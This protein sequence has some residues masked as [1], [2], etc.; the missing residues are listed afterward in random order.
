M[1]TFR[2][3]AYQ[4]ANWDWRTFDLDRDTALADK[5]AGFINALDPNL[6]KF[7]DRGGKLVMY[8]GWNDTAIAPENSVNYYSSV[9][10]RMGKNQD[11]WLRLFM[12]PGMG[13]CRGGPGPNEF[14]GLGVLERWR[15][16]GVAPDQIVGSNIPVGMTRPL[17]PY[18]HVA[19]Y[20]GSGNPND[21]ASFVCKAPSSSI[22]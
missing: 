11:D 16:S 21:A 17:C 18:P 9:L 2:Y 13:H 3:L 12:I 8:H 4:D 10:E 15:E 1:D 5:K 22:P 6:K 14:D 19:Q 7:K 20:K